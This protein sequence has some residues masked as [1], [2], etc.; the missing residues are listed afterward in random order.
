MAGKNNFE[1]EEVNLS[2]NTEEIATLDST[3][4]VLSVIYHATN[5]AIM[6]HHYQDIMAAQVHKAMNGDTTSAKFIAELVEPKAE[7]KLDDND[8][9][10]SDPVQWEVL[11]L[12]LQA[13]LNYQGSAEELVVKILQHA[14]RWSNATLLDVV[15]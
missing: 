9:L 2:L 8:N 10:I 12:S 3:P 7:D 13:R 14:M 1:I 5:K 15:N 6:L 4:E 11:A